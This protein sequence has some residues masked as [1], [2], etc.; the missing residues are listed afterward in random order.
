MAFRLKP[1]FSFLPSLISVAVFLL[2]WKAAASGIRADIILPPPERVISQF[3]S[4][5][6][7]KKFLFATGMTCLRCLSAFSL[8]LALGLCLGLPAGLSKVFRSL[9][10]PFLTVVRSTPVLAVIVLFLI[11]FPQD[12]VPIVSAV[13]MATPV[14]ISAL[15]EGVRS[16]DPQLV[17]MARVHKVPTRLRFLRIYLPSMT[18][19]A[20]SG[21]SSALSLVWKVVVAGEVLSQPRFAIGTG[22]QNAKVNLET[23]RALAWTLATIILCAI[24]DFLFSLLA[25]RLRHEA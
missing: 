10:A 25:R 22:L 11:W 8:S 7:T 12:I 13:L 16:L 23:A 18:P 9:L 17:E 14:L 21:A 20:V 4:L 6:G 19:F 3:I 2:V 24:T 5:V 1:V 15:S